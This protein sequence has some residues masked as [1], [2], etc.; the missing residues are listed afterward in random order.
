MSDWLDDALEDRPPRPNVRAVN[1][2]LVGGIGAEEL[3]A[4]LARVKG[5]RATKATQKDDRKEA[6]RAL[7]PRLEAATSEAERKALWEG[8][9]EAERNP[10]T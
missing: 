1:D 2:G 4:N 8:L 6:R 5:L 3:E 7:R 9:W 10:K